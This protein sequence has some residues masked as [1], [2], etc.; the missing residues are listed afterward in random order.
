MSLDVVQ[1]YLPII[2]EIKPYF[3]KNISILEVGSGDFGI[4]EF[5]DEKVIGSDLSFVR[6]NRASN[7]ERVVA[8]ATALPFRDN[9][10]DFVVCVDVIEHIP[11]KERVTV[12]KEAFR[13]SRL[14][15]LISVPCGENASQV[16]NR[17]LNFCKPL[18]RILNKNPIFLKEHQK[19]GLPTE[20]EM[21]LL[22]NKVTLN[23]KVKIIKNANITIWFLI[24]LIS[25]PLILITRYTG[26]KWLLRLFGIT[27]A[28]CNFGKTYRK[29]FIVRKC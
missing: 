16:E 26:K 8:S 25:F 5:I 2:K 11:K 1:R 21:V 6:E 14:E 9:T 17:L 22:I 12:I 4:A 15:L 27:L 28:W 3:S 24:M 19:Y 20:E 13:V 18:Y 10:V 7:L 23:S 29:M